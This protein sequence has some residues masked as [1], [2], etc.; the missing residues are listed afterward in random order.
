VAPLASGLAS[1]LA[2]MLGSVLAAVLGAGLEV[3]PLHAPRTSSM[4]ATRARRVR[5]R[6]LAAF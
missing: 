3:E 4:P 1:L 2:A 6:A 5:G